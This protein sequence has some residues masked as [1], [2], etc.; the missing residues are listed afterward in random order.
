[1]AASG[2]NHTKN[3]RTRKAKHF[4]DKQKGYV[5][6]CWVSGHAGITG[7]EEKNE[8]AKQALE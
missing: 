1:M 2:N 4:M 6:L 7:N 8:E 5:T 3:L